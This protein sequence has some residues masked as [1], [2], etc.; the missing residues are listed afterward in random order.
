M[1]KIVLETSRGPSE[2]WID[3]TYDATCVCILSSHPLAQSLSV[4]L[5][6]ARVSKTWEKNLKLQVYKP[7]SVD[8]PVPVYLSYNTGE[9][10][11]QL[12]FPKIVP[13]YILLYACAILLEIILIFPETSI[14]LFFYNSKEAIFILDFYHALLYKLINVLIVDSKPISVQHLD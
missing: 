4:P 2:R 11:T 12:L 1:Y 9:D 6:R 13:F 7:E 14:Y 3:T 8:E 10:Y 5:G